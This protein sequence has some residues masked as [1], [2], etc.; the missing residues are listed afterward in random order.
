MLIKIFIFISKI[1]LGYL[2][3]G[4]IYYLSGTIYNLTVGKDIVFSPI[5]G[6]P[7]TLLGWPSM[8]YADF[9]HRQTLGIKPHLVLT[10]IAVGIVL[11]FVLRDIIK[12]SSI[13]KKK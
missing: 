5:I 9:I 8:L 6:L 11:I 12:L 7:L 1:I 4:V 13:C 2:I 10:P 3:P